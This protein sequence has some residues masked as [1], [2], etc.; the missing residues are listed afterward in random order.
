MTAI[1]LSNTR[2][3]NKV[4]NKAPIKSALVIL[5]SL[6]TIFLNCLPKPIRKPVLGMNIE[7][8]RKCKDI[9]K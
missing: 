7:V 6:S 9:A 2:A 4:P 1:L 3:E 8:R 5:L